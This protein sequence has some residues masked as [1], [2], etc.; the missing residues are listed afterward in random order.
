VLLEYLVICHLYGHAAWAGGLRIVNKHGGLSNGDYLAGWSYLIPYMGTFIVTAPLA[1]GSFLLF[2][3][4]GFRRQGRRLSDACE[5]SHE[6]PMEHR[7]LKGIRHPL[8]MLHLKLAGFWLTVMVISIATAHWIGIWGVILLTFGGLITLGVV[9]GRFKTRYIMWTMLTTC[10]PQCG[11]GPMNYKGAS[12]RDNH[13]LLICEKCQIVW[14]LGAGTGGGNNYDPTAL[15]K[16]VLEI[17]EKQIQNN[18]PPET[19]QTIERLTKEG[20]TVD[21][22]RR[23]ISTAAMVE[24]FHIVCD[25]KPFNGERFVWNLAQLPRKP[26]DVQGR[27]FYKLNKCATVMRHAA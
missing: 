7:S 21:E 15:A 23:L 27:E 4:I 19:R 22:A 8:N 5:I 16:D 9:D 25:R 12:R 20:N 18:D 6:N 3:Y 1:I 2:R 26:W 24:V 10:C 17:I 13:G 14:D 11:M